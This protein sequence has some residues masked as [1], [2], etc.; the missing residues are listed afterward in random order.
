[1][2]VALPVVDRPHCASNSEDRRA[3]LPIEL[4]SIEE[5]LNTEK[6]KG[7][8]CKD[9]QL[10]SSMVLIART[11]SLHFSAMDRLLQTNVGFCWLKS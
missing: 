10:L 7:G 3:L 4:T 6:S 11:G 9:L 1:M 5:D 2:W 8:C